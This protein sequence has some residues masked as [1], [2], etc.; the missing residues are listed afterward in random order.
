MSLPTAV[1]SQQLA[2]IVLVS[3]ATAFLARKMGQPY[4][5]AY[6]GTGI[7]LG[8]ASLGLV[9]RSGLTS[10]LSELGLAFL[11]FLIGIEIEFDQLTEIASDL[12]KISAA[13]IAAV[14][15]VG[16]LLSAALGFSLAES[17]VLGVAFSFSS[18]AV[19]VKLLSDKDEL[20]TLHGKIDTGILLFQD[21][22]VVL[23]LTA[24]STAGSLGSVLKGVAGISAMILLVA[25]VAFYLVRNYLDAWFRRVADREH[26][27][28]VQSVAW[29]LLVVEVSRFLGASVEIG[30]F[31]AGLSIAQIPYSSEVVHRLQPLTDLFLALF[32]VNVGLGLTSSAFSVLGISAI[33]A[34]ILMA[35]KFAVIF[36]LVDRSNFTPETSFLSSINMLQVSEFALVLGAAAFASDLIG[37]RA[38]EFVTLTAIISIAASTYLIRHSGVIDRRLKPVL[39]LMSTEGGREPSLEELSGH[40]VV[41]GYDA[42]A[43]QL[44]EKASESMEVVV[45]DDNPS[46]VENLSSSDYEYVYGDFKGERIRRSARVSKASIVV[47]SAEGRSLNEYVV[48]EAEGTVFVTAETEEEAAELYDMGAHYVILDDR[49][50]GEALAEM[51]KKALND[52]VEFAE[53][54]RRIE[55]NTV[56]GDGSSR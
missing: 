48:E 37:S 14:A 20:A 15:A 10:F 7:I 1:A 17:L 56:W 39:D 54:A 21:L 40:V 28:F 42:I 34:G 35:V 33:A 45:V 26:M 16:G 5:V 13:Q 47:C 32:F 41:V 29:L 22:V 25:P 9:Q 43:R 11:L 27:F 36:V 12:A 44:A 55:H 4:V 30:A 53:D 3:A 6:L 49:D 19:V 24:V 38:L 50:S 31:L 8:P 18:T 2:L 52:P 51:V 23:T 46:K